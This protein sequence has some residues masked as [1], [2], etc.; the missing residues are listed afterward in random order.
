MSAVPRRG[1]LAGLGWPGRV[2][3]VIGGLLLAVALVGGLVAPYAPDALVGRTF[4]PPGP[5][6]LLGTDSLGRDVLSRI[7]AGGRTAVI[8]AVAAMVVAEVVGIAIG[9]LAGYHG[10]RIDAIL[11]RAVDVL[12]AFPALLLVLIL[13]AGLGVGP[14]V[15]V[16]GVALVNIPGIARIVRA[17]TLEIGRSGFVESAIVRGESTFSVLRREILPNVMTTIVADGG[18]RLAAAFLIIAGLNF[19]GIGIQPPAADWSTMVAE[20]RSYITL[21]PWTII[22]PTACIALFTISVNVVA[23]SLARARSRSG[24]RP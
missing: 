3:L 9:L 16:I 11:M 1:R 24:G 8:L 15:L 14:R 5:D 10:G 12:L 21:Q 18:V 23:E 6:H 4:L 20:N 13:A 17:A 22:A 19:V 7:L 2:F